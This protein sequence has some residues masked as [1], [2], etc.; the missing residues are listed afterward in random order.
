MAVGMGGVR[1]LG[2]R[3]VDVMAWADRHGMDGDA[4]DLLDQCVRA[5]DDAFAEDFA[6]KAANQK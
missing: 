1:P 6:R 4:A 3:W 5:L 2:I